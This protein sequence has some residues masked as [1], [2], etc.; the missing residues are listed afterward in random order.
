MQYG[1]LVIMQLLTPNATITNFVMHRKNAKNGLDHHLFKP[2]H[3]SIV[4]IFLFLKVWNFI[5]HVSKRPDAIIAS[6]VCLCKLM[7]TMIQYFS[8]LMLIFIFK[9]HILII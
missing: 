2:L 3:C 5:Q 9:A 8:Y 7:H 1:K 6:Y 4:D